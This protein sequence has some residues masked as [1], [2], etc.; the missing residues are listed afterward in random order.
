MWGSLTLSE[1]DPQD[2]ES[3]F[4]LGAGRHL[5]RIYLGLATYLTRPVT[6]EPAL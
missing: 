6:E 2:S 1:G 3:L 4:A 5:S